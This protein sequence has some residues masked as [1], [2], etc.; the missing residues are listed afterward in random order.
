LDGLAASNVFWA[1]FTEPIR[2]EFSFDA[3]SL[4]QATEQA[5]IIVRGTM[6]EL[7]VGELWTIDDFSYPLHYVKVRVS[8]LLKG[9]LH[10]REDG[11][12]EVQ[13]GTVDEERFDALR[14]SVPQHDGLWFL[15]YEPDWAG[16]GDSP[17]ASAEIAPYA[18]FLTNE[19]Q[20][21]L[22]DIDGSVR[23]VQPDD[24][25]RVFGSDYFPL[26]L[27]GASFAEVVE[28]TRELLANQP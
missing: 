2:G 3:K 6:S 4:A 23:L 17:M 21:M 1:N 20:G 12:V 14:T 27:E 13:M 15:M 26:D 18:Y 5:D 7:Y 10:A 11:Y 9:E 19:Y 16:R 8:E 22:R 25:E 24:L 28:E